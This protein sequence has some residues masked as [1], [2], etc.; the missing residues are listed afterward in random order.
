MKISLSSKISNFSQKLIYSAFYY[1]IYLNKNLLFIT[2]NMAKSVIIYNIIY[3]TGSDML[4][5]I[6]TAAV[7]TVVMSVNANAGGGMDHSSHSAV[8]G[9]SGSGVHFFGRL[10]VGYDQKAT[11]SANSVDSIRD[12]GLKSRLGIKFKENLGGLTMLGHAEWKFDIADGWATSDSKNCST[13]ANGSSPCQT[14]ELH[15]GHLGF[16]TPLGYLGMGSYETPYKTMGM[17]DHNMDTAIGMNGHGATSKTAFGIAGT[18]DSGIMYSGKVGPFEIAYLRGMGENANN[19]NVAKND[20]SFGIRTENLL[21]AGLELGVARTFD[22]SGGADGESNDK[23]F[24]SYKVMPGLGVFYTIED[25]E[26]GT[27]S[28]T[29]FTNGEGDIETFGAHYTMGMHNIQVVYATG[30]SREVA[31]N[32]DY[33]TLG[34][35]N[36]MQLSKST[37][38]TIGYIRQGMQGS[39]NAVRTYGLGITHSF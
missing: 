27:T 29:G 10:Y 33:R 6:C 37:D 15:V 7:F 39:G 2:E 1:V 21:L 35:S 14:I 30:D 23:I 22:K 24:A 12:N 38:I 3:Q 9:K 5:K 34:L 31:A 18:W 19:N 36:R 26:I 4:R 32:E 11:G 17:Y 28:A 20:Y 16:M 25:L 8:A 13:D